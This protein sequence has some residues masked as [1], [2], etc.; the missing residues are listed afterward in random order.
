[1]AADLSQTHRR[2]QLTLRA[3]TLRDL[4]RLWPSFDL[5]RMATT[6]PVFEEAALLLVRERGR[7]SAGLAA[8][9]YRAARRA[10]GIAGNPP[11]MRATPAAE[12]I[13]AGLRVMGPVNAARQLV[14]GRALSD[15]GRTTL[16]NLMGV[17]SKYVLDHG[18]DTLLNAV[19][20]DP[21]GRGW[22]RVA[23]GIACNFCSNLAGRTYG[24][25]TGASFPSHRHCACTAAPVW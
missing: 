17:V 23:G 14:L 11:A 9:Y 21:R 20:D 13:V 3:A 6:W 24:S 7:T 22:T 18:R 1:V 15:V 19:K 4:L 2:A 12:V 10:A 8:A 25:E 5:A 16:V